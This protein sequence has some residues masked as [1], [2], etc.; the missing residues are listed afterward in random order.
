MIS[1]VLESH[2]IKKFRFK[3]DVFVFLFCFVKLF[4]GKLLRL[5]NLR[6]GIELINQDTFLDQLTNTFIHFAIKQPSR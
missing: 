5:D 2:G 4:F 6:S 3:D 1:Y